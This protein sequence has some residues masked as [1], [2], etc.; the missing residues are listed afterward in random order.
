VKQAA[1]N[2]V[3]LTELACLETGCEFVSP[4]PF[5]ACLDELALHFCPEGGDSQ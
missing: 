2:E 5:P 3:P 4:T 1:P